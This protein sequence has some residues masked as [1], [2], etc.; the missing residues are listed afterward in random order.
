MHNVA[1][2][3]LYRYTK[4][5]V[6][7]EISMKCA[8]LQAYSVG[9]LNRSRCMM[10]DVCGQKIRCVCVCVCELFSAECVCSAV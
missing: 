2:I 1:L 4:C 3:K 10:D 7:Q 6:S 5:D 9:V 8:N